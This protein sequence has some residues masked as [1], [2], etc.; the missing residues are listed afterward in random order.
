MDVARKVVVLA[1]ECGMD[2]E[3]EDLAIESLVPEKLRS[4]S[5][6]DTF[7]AQ[8]PEAHKSRSVI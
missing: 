3:L 8:L 2:I 6:P 4:I 7:L 5:D 1:R